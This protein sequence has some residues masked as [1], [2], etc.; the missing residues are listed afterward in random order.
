MSS[1]YKHRVRVGINTVVLVLSTFAQL[2]TVL[3]ADTTVF[4]VPP[5]EDRWILY[6]RLIAEVEPRSQPELL[7]RLRLREMLLDDSGKDY[8]YPDDGYALNVDFLQTLDTEALETFFEGLE[9]EADFRFGQLLTGADSKLNTSLGVGADVRL[10][11]GSAFDLRLDLEALYYQGGA[12]NDSNF[13]KEWYRG[14]VE[15][16][17][18]PWETSEGVGLGFG[19]RSHERYNTPTSTEYDAWATVGPAVRFVSDSFSADFVAGYYYSIE[20]LDDDLPRDHAGLDRQDLDVDSNGFGVHVRVS[21][22]FT[23]GVVASAEGDIHVDS[24][25]FLRR[26]GAALSVRIPVDFVFESLLNQETSESR[27]RALAVEVG[28]EAS[29]FDLG[30]ERR[31]ALPF[32]SNVAAN[33][34]LVYF[35]E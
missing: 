25:S 18:I 27:E 12:K 32:N 6:G 20:E 1:R 3:I 16:D 10:Q 30:P 33:L 31:R 4:T 14:R 15:L 34:N 5:P 8:L 28:V 35:L 24:A 22:K 9:P 21:R 2:P 19:L 11:R 13:E 29:Y 23:T 26:S 17:V 7:D